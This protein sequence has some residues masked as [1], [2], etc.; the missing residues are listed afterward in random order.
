MELK[1][2]M[3][4]N[5]L[6]DIY[7]EL[8]TE[9][10]RLYYDY[11]YLKDYSLSEISELL[12]VSRNAIHMQLKHVVNHLETYE[13]TLKVYERKQKINRLIDKIDQE[14]LTVDAIKQALEKV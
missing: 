12:S 10:Q 3:K 4:L 5:D 6:Y 14:D 2:K 8:L 13:E 7:G 11:Y 9:K 1:D